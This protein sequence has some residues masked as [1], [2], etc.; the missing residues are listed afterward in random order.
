MKKIVLTAIL[1]A[2]LGLTSC[3][4]ENTTPLS[5]QTEVDRIQ[6]EITVSETNDS[7]K[8]TYQYDQKG[9]LLRVDYSQDSTY[10]IYDYSKASQ[11]IETWYDKNQ[12]IERVFTHKLNTK[13]YV[14]TT[15]MIGDDT[16]L[17]PDTS[18]YDEND[19]VYFK[20]DKNIVKDG[21]IILN[22]EGSD[23]IF[24]DFYLDKTNALSNEMYGSSFQGKT[25]KNLLKKW[26]FGKYYMEDFEYELDAFGKVMTIFVKRTDLQSTQISKVIV[27]YVKIKI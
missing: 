18:F 1:F 15:S 10:H 12:K 25:S 11:L 26:K 7:I 19:F 6:S 20:G 16:V 4:K 9:R 2:I 21:N 22:I 8:V 24:Q 5:V 14:Q 23:T 17:F 27:K 3:K 13:G